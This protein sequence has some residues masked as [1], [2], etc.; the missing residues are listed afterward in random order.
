MKTHGASTALE[1]GTG[2]ET[3]GSGCGEARTRVRP[4]WTTAGGACSARGEAQ[5]GE[6]LKRLK[7]SQV[8]ERA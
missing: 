3:E 6:A 7:G 2:L 1:A 5:E 8:G 4:G